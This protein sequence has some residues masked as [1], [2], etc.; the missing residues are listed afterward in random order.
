MTIRNIL[1]AGVSFPCDVWVCVYNYLGAGYISF[2][3]ALDGSGYLDSD[4]R[5][6]YTDSD[7]LV[8][9]LEFD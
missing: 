7:T 8:I 1:D 5:C 2:K 4:I 3:E 6:I 9:E